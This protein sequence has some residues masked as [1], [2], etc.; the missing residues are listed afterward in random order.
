MRTEYSWLFIFLILILLS[1]CSVQVGDVDVESGDDTTTTTSSTTT[2]TTTSTTGTTEEG[3]TT[4]TT[5]D[6][7]T[8]STTTSTTGTTEEGATTT[9]TTGQET[10]TPSTTTTTTST[11]GTIEEGA[12]TTTTTTTSSTTSTTS[13][14]TSTSSTTST[15][16]KYTS[17][18]GITLES[19]I[20]EVK[21][22]WGNPNY[23]TIESTNN[24]LEYQYGVLAPII[25]SY[26]VD[27]ISSEGTY[28]VYAIWDF[29]SFSTWFGVSKNDPKAVVQSLWGTATGVDTTEAYEYWVY[30]NNLGAVFDLSTDKVIGLLLID[31]DETRWANP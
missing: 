31:F 23:T 15:L 28:V 21:A 25:V 24:Y 9:T 16:L 19:T 12:T 8:T 13:T 7:T 27:F 29:T 4:T 3:A 18:R 30:Q 2:T 22:A 26:A 1:G 20:P 6:T 11:T 14:T 5:A 17:Y 10:T